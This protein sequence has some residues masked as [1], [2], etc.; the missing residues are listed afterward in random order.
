M[1]V[2]SYDA[3]L[4]EQDAYPTYPQHRTATR[5]SLTQLPKLTLHAQDIQRAMADT[6]DFPYFLQIQVQTTV[7]DGFPLKSQY[8]EWL[9]KYVVSSVYAC[10][11]LIVIYLWLF[12]LPEKAPQHASVQKSFPK[13]CVVFLGIVY[14]LTYFTIDQYVPSFPQMEK[15]LSGTQS[16]MSLTVQLNFIVKAVFGLL[17]AG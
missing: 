7:V 4:Q 9:T 8:D 14:T 15:D 17:T 1:C 11:I 12:G 5:E 2:L 13:G 3:R 16:L 6:C 10:L